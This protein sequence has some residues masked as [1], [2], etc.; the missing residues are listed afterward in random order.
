V[1]D[2]G[3]QYMFGPSLMINPVTEYKARSRDVYLP[4][5]Y[6]W[7]DLRTGE[8]FTGGKVINADAPYSS[9]PVFVREGAILPIGPDLQYTSEKPADPLT[10]FVFTGL[11]GM[12]TLYEDEGVNNNY[13]NGAYTLIPFV[14]TEADRT[15]T[16][17][18]RKGEFTGMMPDR[19]F[20]VVVI[21]KEKPV[22]PD[23]N[24]APDKVIR[25]SGEEIIVEL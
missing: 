17:G 25:Y 8:Y 22:R 24:A 12:F 2:I 16:V 7:Y 21:S 14:Y 13:E 19:T 11:D 3:D 5:P 15:L 9:I 23:F 1:N 18:A 4:G 6:G 20:N 10:L